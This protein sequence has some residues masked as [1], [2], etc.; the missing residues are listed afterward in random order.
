MIFKENNTNYVNFL[1]RF[2]FIAVTV[3]RKRK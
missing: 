3:K 2:D 1:F